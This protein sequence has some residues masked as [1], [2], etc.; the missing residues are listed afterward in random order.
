MGNFSFTLVHAASLRESVR[1]LF[2]TQPRTEKVFV[3]PRP[4]NSDAGS[5]K[6]NLVF[7]I[8]QQPVGQ[9]Q[10]LYTK[11]RIFACQTNWFLKNPVY[12]A[13]RILN[14]WPFGQ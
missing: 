3:Y 5:W 8:V 6:V 2:Y 10:H 9:F 7:E 11:G 1:L 12:P 14:L 13:V 4:L